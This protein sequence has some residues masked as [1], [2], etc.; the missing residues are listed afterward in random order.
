[1]V[2]GETNFTD[3]PYTALQYAQGSRGVLLVIQ[4]RDE[5]HDERQDEQHD[6]QHDERH[7]E[8]QDE[9][10]SDHDARVH[11]ADW[12]KEDA[13]RFVLYGSF[14][15]LLV[16]IVEA[17]VLRAALKRMGMMKLS[18]RDEERARL[19]RR[20]IGILLQVR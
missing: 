10:G 11:R 6:E 2:H 7:D 1:M 3:C 20:E 14:D 12:L 9:H 8:R 16:G 4:Q 15:H 18:V 19:L 13:K 5:Q 17:K